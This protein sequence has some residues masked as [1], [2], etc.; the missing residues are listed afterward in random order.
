MPETD[1]GFSDTPEGVSGSYLL[2]ALGPTIRVNI[3]FDKAWRAGLSVTPA[4]AI[5]NVDALVDTGAA[6]SFIDDFLAVSLKLPCIDKEQPIAGSAG[7]HLAKMYLAQ[8]YVPSLNWTIYGSFAGVQLQAGGQSHKALLG[9]TFLQSF[10]LVYE[11]K[12]G[13]VTLTT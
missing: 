3:G 2:A 10:K 5:E 7:R 8:I 9:R 6:V 11:G 12:T 4:P 13:K 1:C